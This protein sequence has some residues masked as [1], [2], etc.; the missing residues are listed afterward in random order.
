MMSPETRSFYTGYRLL[1][2]ILPTYLLTALFFC[3]G[4]YL[5]PFIAG[6]EG[7]MWVGGVILFVGISRI[8]SLLG[9]MLSPVPRSLVSPDASQAGKLHEAL[10]HSDADAQPRLVELGNVPF[11]AAGGLGPAVWIS[12]YTL[13]R[14]QV[15]QLSCL[16][17]HES[18]HLRK[19]CSFAWW[20]LLWLLPWPL[21]WLL[22]AQP[23]YY[24]ASAVLFAWC[25]L[26]LQSW[27]RWCDEIAA[28]K[29]AADVCGRGQYAR[30]MVR[31]LV[32]FETVPQSPLRRSRLAALGFTKPEIDELLQV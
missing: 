26:R 21:G 1:T 3:A 20:D 13:E 19:G 10:D 32:E 31:H 12:T 8:A 25:W 5:N 9:F 23:A 15:E 22:A 6:H 28:D 24:L 27:L 18:E 14:L 2:S 29:A 16:L 17:R 11:L 30:A 4:W 7:V